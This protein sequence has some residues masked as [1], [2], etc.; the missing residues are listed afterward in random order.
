M[1]GNFDPRDLHAILFDIDGTLADTDDVYVRRLARKLRPF[2]RLFRD[3]N[4]TLFARRLVMLADTPMNSALM[5][6]DKL[7]LDNILAPFYNR[8]RQWRGGF[9]PYNISLIP[10]VLSTLLHLHQNYPLAII[11]TRGSQSTKEFLDNCR[12]AGLFQVVATIRTVRRT[13]PHPDPIL[14]AADQLGIT[15]RECLMVGDTTVDIRAARSAGAKSVGVLSG[16]GS[17]RELR[18][19]G[20]DVVLRDITELVNLLP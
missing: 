16:F 3:H 7:G 11:T 19:A 13:K 20:A 8:V 18:R 2:R 4:P 15:P 5:I 10:G 9:H 6:M 17:E 1:R 12:L 14:W